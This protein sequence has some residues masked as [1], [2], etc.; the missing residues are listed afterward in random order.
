MNQFNV[1]PICGSLFSRLKTAEKRGN[2]DEREK[3]REKEIRKIMKEMKRDDILWANL[4]R[5]F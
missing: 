2:W 1:Y 5:D 4:V 3:I